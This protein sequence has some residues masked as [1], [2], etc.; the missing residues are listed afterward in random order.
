[1]EFLTEVT[2][3]VPEGVSDE[4]VQA[5]IA[6]ERERARELADQGH[7]VRIWRP[8]QSGWANV[9]LW[10]ARD[11]DEL[12]SILATLP[13]HCWMSIRIRP[14]DLHPSDPVAQQRRSGA[15]GPTKSLDSARGSL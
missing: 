15:S 1:M 13:L 9:G 7:L 6:A 3:T 10:S 12:N 5:A 8:Q 14:L 11:E 4:T 2:I